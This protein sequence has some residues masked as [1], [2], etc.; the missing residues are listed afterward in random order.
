[1][2]V[3]LCF[4]LMPF[5]VKA[6]PD[7]SSINFDRVYQEIIAPAIRDAQLEPLR[8]D[9][10]TSSGIIHKP[11]F[12]R[13][14]LCKYAVA[15]LTMAN[16]NVYYELG[17][18]HACRPWSTVQI[19]AAG[20][21]LPFDVQMLRTVPYTLATDG[22]P[23]G[24]KM[25]ETRKTIT[26]FLNE[27]KK[28]SKDSPLYQLLDGFKE[29]TLPHEKTDV[30]REQVR[31]SIEAKEKLAIARKKDVEA[32]REVEKELGALD[33]LESGV[34]IDL[35][36]SY[37]AV[38]AWEDMV[39]LVQRMPEPI[40]QTT[41]VREQ[42]GFALNRA[43]RRSE[44]E[45]VLRALLEEKGPSSETFGLLGRVYKDLWEDAVKAKLPMLAA[46]YLE[47]AMETYLSGFQADW[48]DAF[49][50]VNTLTLMEVMEPPDE[51]RKQINPVVRY[52]VDRK[53]A[54]GNPDYW[55]YATQLELA[56]LAMDETSATRALARASACIR[57][58][59][60]PETTLRNLRLI[61]EAREKRGVL[62]AWTKEVEDSLGTYL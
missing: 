31:Y 39:S 4:V 56:V 27:A 54:R 7:G 14:V 32:V 2:S 13:L 40:A 11:M 48:R 5:G 60:E 50:G 1:M 52:A 21:R 44:A 3:P 49:P 35:Y 6:S 16:A 18:R 33:S 47:R 53:I 23:D 34:V 17:V 15:D 25:I 37:R 30:F 9:E 24:E 42:L 20:N 12:E 10:E 29:P 46:G 38:K 43:G 22:G 19:L 28:E 45:R 26:A 55:D 59:W 58:K 51:R 62:L 57:E 41:L 8:A 36:L 61:R